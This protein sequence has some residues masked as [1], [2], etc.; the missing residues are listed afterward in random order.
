M[1]VYRSVECV[2]LM[3]GG[4]RHCPKGRSIDRSIDSCSVGYARDDADAMGF[5]QRPIGSTHRAH[6]QHGAG[7]NRWTDGMK[8]W[9]INRQGRGASIKAPNTR[10]IDRRGPRAPEEP[11]S[12]RATGLAKAHSTRAPRIKHGQTPAA[13]GQPNRVRSGFGPYR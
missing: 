5:D 3:S 7:L 6:R 12:R 2:D 13:G 11:K 1:N 8:G 10:W 9:E 4:H